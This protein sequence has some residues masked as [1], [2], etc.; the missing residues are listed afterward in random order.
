M[1]HSINHLPQSRRYPKVKTRLLCIFIAFQG[2][3]EQENLPFLD[4]MHHSLGLKSC[5]GAVLKEEKSLVR[6]ISCK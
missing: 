5:W 6:A 2:E 1:Y 4:S 3:A